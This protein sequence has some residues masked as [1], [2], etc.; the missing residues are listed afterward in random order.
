[1]VVLVIGLLVSPRGGERHPWE[2]R[3]GTPGGD[4]PR[5]GAGKNLAM[6]APRPDQTPGVRPRAGG[7][8]ARE[9]GLVM[10]DV[11]T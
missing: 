3:T 8:D 1:V 6:T 10:A 11:L 7:E 4:T 9:H 5:R 2:G